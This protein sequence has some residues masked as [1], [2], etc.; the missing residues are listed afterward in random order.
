MW[1]GKNME[2]RIVTI[3]GTTHHIG[4]VVD[5]TYDRDFIRVHS[6]SDVAVK[7][8]DIFPTDKVI[9]IN[10]MKWKGSDYHG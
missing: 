4:H 3:D 5:Y 1:K 10:V 2:I 6:Q 8:I 7:D 9:S